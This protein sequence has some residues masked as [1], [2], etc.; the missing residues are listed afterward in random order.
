MAVGPGDRTRRP[1]S[2]RPAR[3]RARRR[4][5]RQP[6]LGRRDLRARRRTSPG[7]RPAVPRR[8]T[9]GRHRSSTGDL[10]EL[11]TAGHHRHRRPA[12]AASARV[13]SLGLDRLGEARPG[14]PGAQVRSIRRS[15]ATSSRSGHDNISTMFTLDRAGGSGSSSPGSGTIHRVLP[16]YAMVA[17]SGLS[18]I[19]VVPRESLATLPAAADA[20]GAGTRR[21]ASGAGAALPRDRGRAR[22]C[23]TAT[24]RTVR[25][26]P[27]ARVDAERRLRPG[28]GTRAP[29]GLLPARTPSPG[30]V[31]G[32]TRYVGPDLGDPVRD[33]HA[34]TTPS[35][36]RRRSGVF[37]WTGG[38]LVRIRM[39]PGDA[40]RPPAP[41]CGSPELAYSLR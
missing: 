7:L 23:R 18:D 8:P 6:G 22:L 25:D 9:T 14:A 17:I 30:D 2:S 29:T 16:G 39:P 10:V 1:R 36:C 41:S 40:P 31:P 21:P 3:R 4:S 12:R 37:T 34:R 20:P 38:D 15:A 24:G 5:R 27:D 11:G 19:I 32:C 26:R 35:S 33:D 13:P 28:R